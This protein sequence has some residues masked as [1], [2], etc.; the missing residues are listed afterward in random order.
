MDAVNGRVELDDEAKSCL[1]WSLPLFG[2]GG[3]L[4]A[5]ARLQGTLTFDG[6]CQRQQ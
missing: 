4:G 5:P 1:R 3:G 2:G 6:A